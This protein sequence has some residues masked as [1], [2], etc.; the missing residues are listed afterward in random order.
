MATALLDYADSVLPALKELETTLSAKVN[1]TSIT[2]GVVRI[3]WDLSSRRITVRIIGI[4]AGSV[5]VKLGSVDELLETVNSVQSLLTGGL[6]STAQN[7][8]VDLG[9]IPSIDLSAFNGMRRNNTSSC[10]ILRAVFKFVYD[11]REPVIGK[12]LRGNLTLGV[13]DGSF[14]VYDTIGNLVGAPSGYQS[15]MV[16]NIV[17]SLLLNNTGWF[18]ADEIA[19]YNDGTKEFV[20]DEVLLD[21]LTTVVV[22]KMASVLITYPD[23]TNSQSR[24]SEIK[25]YMTANGINYAAAARALGYDPDVVYS[26]EFVSDDGGYANVLL[27]A[28][29]SP[30][31]N[32]LP[33]ANTEMLSISKTDSL[34]QV[35][36]NALKIAWNSVLQET[37]NTLHVNNYVERGYGSNFDNEFY[38]WQRESANGG[39]DYSNAAANYTAAKVESWAAAVYES[40]NAASAE[41]FLGWVKDNYVFDR[42][43]AEDAEGTWADIESQTLFNKLR[44]SPLADYYFD[45]QTGPLNLYLSQTGTSKLDEFFSNGYSSYSS[46]TAMLNDVLV[47]V[48]KDLFPTGSEN[49]KNIDADYPALATTGSADTQTVVGALVDNTMKVLQYTA[50]ATD[51]NI[52]NGFYKGGGTVLAPSNLEEAMIPLLISCIGNVWLNGNGS[53][54]DLIHPSDWDKCRDAEA[55]VFVTFCN[56]EGIP[57]IR[58]GT[59]GL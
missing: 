15:N 9:D 58:S 22:Q 50:D 18:T 13:I 21:K 41:E 26:D 33:T 29:G 48:V 36:F 45:M 4:E 55:V 1:G 56:I 10:D 37:L 51:K 35:G 30:D 39:W 5:T 53:L 43:A 57:L 6:V 46:L 25:A 38:Y 32:G 12:F 44:Y 47:A 17:K 16:Y 54:A 3:N 31:D 8:G 23:G 24:Y 42:E 49:G 27:F 19:A 40:Y 14:N 59:E 34:L 11:N 7:L 2:G 52:L 20:L 28:Y